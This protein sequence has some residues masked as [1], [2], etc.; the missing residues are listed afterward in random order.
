[1]LSTADAEVRCRG[2]HLAA[3]ELVGPRVCCDSSSFLVPAMSDSCL[4]ECVRW[5]VAKELVGTPG[6]GVAGL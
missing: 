5:R 3:H 2:S 6:E 4:L 1:M